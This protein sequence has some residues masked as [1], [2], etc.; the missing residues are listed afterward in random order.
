MEKRI[1]SDDD[2]RK[3][4]GELEQTVTKLT[5]QLENAIK[6]LDAFTYSISH[7]LRAPLR[8]INGYAN[9]MRVDYFTKLDRKG[10]KFLD[11]ILKGSKKMGDLIDDLQAFSRLGR[12][13]EAITELN[14]HSLVK[15][16]KI[17][18]MNEN[19]TAID[20]K[21][22]ELLPSKGQ[23]TLIKQV[24]VSLIS[25]AIKFSKNTPPIE[26]EIGSYYNDNNDQVVYYIK[27]TGVGFDMNYYDK[28]F[29]VFQRLHSPDEYEGSGIGLA[30]VKKIISN[31]NGTVWAESKVNEGSCFYF[32][33]PKI[34]S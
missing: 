22:H 4:N 8:A 23:R 29:K 3:I 26:I 27:D 11:A 6:D 15:S 1:K 33:L 17:D 21:I 16:I 28:L 20:L 31:H 32:S 2:I 7:D 18:E 25:N 34:T 9:I 24:W 12:Q 13:V 10:M 5:V 14:M 19:E 30:I